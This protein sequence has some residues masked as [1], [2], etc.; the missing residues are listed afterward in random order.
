MSKL[1]PRVPEPLMTRRHVEP[2]RRELVERDGSPGL[3]RLRLEAQAVSK[4][5]DGAQ[6]TVEALSTVSIEAASGEFVAIVGPSGCGKSTLLEILA[7]L[8]TPT[9]GTVLIDGMEM[10]GR[11]GAVGYM[12]QKDLLLPWRSVLD[13]TILA[14][15][16]AGTPRRRP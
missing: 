5:Y 6:G 4:L 10:T 2:G 9:S 13:N 11:V 15:D 1:S 8:Q 3:R 14:L 16:V 7:G 12:P